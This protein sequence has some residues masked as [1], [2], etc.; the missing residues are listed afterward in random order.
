MTALDDL[1]TLGDYMRHRYASNRDRHRWGIAHRA[2]LID[3]GEYIRTSEQRG[4]GLMQFLVHRPEPYIST[5]EVIGTRSRH[6]NGAA[7]WMPSTPGNRHWPGCG[8]K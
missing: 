6:H 1:R 8:C 4:M 5:T 2:R 3:T 7:L